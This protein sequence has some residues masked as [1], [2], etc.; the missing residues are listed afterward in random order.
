MASPGPIVAR[1]QNAWAEQFGLDFVA[2]ALAQLRD[3]I[4]VAA[5]V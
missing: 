3:A 4:P 2:E 1:L 5:G